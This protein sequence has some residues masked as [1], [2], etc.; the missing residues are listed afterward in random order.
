MRG[1]SSLLCLGQ[2]PLSQSFFLS[3]KLP[4]LFFGDPSPIFCQSSPAMNPPRPPARVCSGA[5]SLAPCNRRVAA[6]FFGDHLGFLCLTPTPCYPMHTSLRPLPL[7]QVAGIPCQCWPSAAGLSRI[8]QATQGCSGVSRFGY[9][10]L[11]EKKSLPAAQQVPQV[12]EEA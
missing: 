6:P 5:Q 10:A 12:W 3:G 1:T 9:Q 8:F 7:A 2:N 4:G 11:V